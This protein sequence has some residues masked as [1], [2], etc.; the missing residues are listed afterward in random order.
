MKLNILI[1]SSSFINTEGR[2]KSIYYDDRINIIEFPGPNKEKEMLKVISKIDGVIC[3]DDEFTERV[4]QKGVNSRLKVISK[5]GT[6]LD[7][8]DQESCKRNNI[9]LKN[10]H[11]INHETVA[12]HCFALI[13]YHYKNINKSI[14]TK[15]NNKWNR[16]TGRD[17]KFKNIGILGTGNVG[18]EVIKLSSLFRL[19]VMSYDKK[20]DQNFAKKNNFKYYSIEDIFKKSDIIVLSMSL[21]KD[22]ENIINLEILKLLKK[23]ATIINISRGGLINEADMYNFL[24]VNPE[25]HYLTDVLSKEPIKP[26]HDFLK[27]KNVTITPHIASRTIENVQTQGAMAVEN[28]LSNLNF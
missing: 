14:V 7:S 9:I 1:T 24:K 27:L 20:P 16:F 4:I 2:H 3:G 12:E 6:G 11:G 15:Q 13:L 26:D 5:Y 22:S 21:N 17:L 19:N 23:D 8:I 28:L 18:K 25:V 10:C